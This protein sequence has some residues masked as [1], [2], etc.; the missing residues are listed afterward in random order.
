MESNNISYTLRNRLCTGCGVC[1]DVCPTHSIGIVREGDEWRP[2]LNAATCLG[3]KCG[4]CLKV[5]PGVGC[6]LE[7]MSADLFGGG[8]AHSDRHIGR[9]VG[10]HTGYSTD[11]DIRF[12][13]ASGGMVSQFLIYLLDKKEIDGAVVTAFSEADHLTPVSYIARTREEIL[14]ARSSKY[15]PVAL[16]KVGNEIAKAEGRFVVVGLPCHIQGFRKRAAIDRRFRERVVGYFAIY[17]SSNRTFAAQDFLLGKYGA[18][19]GKIAYFA[20]R[21][22]GCLGN[23]VIRLGGEGAEFPSPAT[24]KDSGCRESKSLISIPYTRYYGALRSFFKPHR[25][26]ACIDH[27]GELADVC[28]GD[29]HIKPYSDDTVGVSSWIVR[30][31]KFERLFR[32]AAAEGYIRMDDVDAHTLNESQKAMLYPKRRR[33]RAVMDIDRLLGRKPPVYGKPLDKP[34]LKDYVAEIV[35]HCQRFVGRHRRL[36]WVI[37]LVGR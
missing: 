4:R 5:C 34:G 20:Y 28:F 7:K 2:R 36:W 8:A 12:H 23:L 14:R 31:P 10:L 21:D 18:E 35:C 11:E 30:N 26:L 29:I 16:D 37:G 27:Y 13:S 3:D 9:Y 19:R 1:G 24:G 25:C 22:N 6:E 17:C 32:Q 33:A 15:C